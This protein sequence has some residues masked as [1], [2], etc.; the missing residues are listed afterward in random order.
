[1]KSEDKYKYDVA[2]WHEVSNWYEK[3]KDKMLLHEN[4]RY[5]VEE[6][7]KLHKNNFLKEVTWLEYQE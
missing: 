6:F 4:T 3:N 2:P 5:H 1:M 7:L